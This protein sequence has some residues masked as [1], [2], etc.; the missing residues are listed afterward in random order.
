MVDL[1]MN[2]PKEMHML[3][4]TQWRYSLSGSAGISEGS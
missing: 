4:E 2:S 1:G 3:N